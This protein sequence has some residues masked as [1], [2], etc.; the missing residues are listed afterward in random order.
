[1]EVVEFIVKALAEGIFCGLICS[2]FHEL[3]VHRKNKKKQKRS[4]Y[5]Q[6]FHCGANK[7]AWEADFD[8]EETGFDR[9][10][11]VNVCQCLNCG[12]EIQYVI[13]DDKE[14]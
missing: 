7:V 12:A 11:I 6:C 2:F 10:G 3:I 9:P 13:F 5:Y 14:E 4:G 1:M 8:A